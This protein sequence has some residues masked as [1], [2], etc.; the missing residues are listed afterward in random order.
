MTDLPILIAGAGIS[1]LLLAQYLQQH[2]IPYRLFEQDAAIDARSGGWGLTLHWALPALRELLPEPLVAQLPETYVNKA[3]AA[4][5]DTGRFPFFD[6][7]TGSV[8]YRVPAAERIRV[9]RVRLRQLLATGL[10][11]AWRKTLTA[12]DST[13]D[14]VT[15]H[16]HDGSSATGRLLIGCDGARSRTRAIQYPDSH[17]MAPL[18]VQLLGGS[19][20]Y[21]AEELAGAEA[22]DP[23]MFQGSHPETNIYFYFSILDTPNNFPD[24]SEDRY[25]CQVIVSW[26]DA[27]GIPVPSDNAARLAL[28]KSLTANWVEPFKGLV[29]R[30]PDSTDVRSIRIADWLFRPEQA[31]AHPRVVLMGDAA[32]TMTMFRGEGANNAIV[33]VLDLTRRVDLRS[34]RSLSTDDLRQS[35]QRYENDVLARAGPS[36]VNS[37]QACLDAHEFARIVDGS[38]LVSARL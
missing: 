29:H 10:E 6:L 35:L 32:H 26:A 3:A 19:A 14:R 34:E 16:F 23:F 4:R 28:M 33:D 36:V 27:Q 13:H 38:P 22:I 25:R 7:Q 24:S 21:S 8:L 15:A 2:Q 11:I 18:P 30:L 17:E 31:P 37:R 12:I 20:L 9:S 5:G 1:G